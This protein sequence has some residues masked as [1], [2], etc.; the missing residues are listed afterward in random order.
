MPINLEQYKIAFTHIK[1]KL[2]NLPNYDKEEFFN[3]FGEKFKNNLS[4]SGKNIYAAGLNKDALAATYKKM[5]EELKSEYVKILD[6]AEKDALATFDPHATV[7]KAKNLLLSKLDELK[8]I[9]CDTLKH[10][11]TANGQI[12]DEEDKKE[13]INVLNEYLDNCGKNPNI[14]LG[15]INGVWP[16]VAKLQL[17]INNEESEFKAKNPDATFALKETDLDKLSIGA[18]PAPVTGLKV[19]KDN[20]SE[21]IMHAS[22]SGRKLDMELILSDWDAIFRQLAEIASHYRNPAIVLL[23]VLIFYFA[24]AI[25]NNEKRVVA[26]I[27]KVIEEKGIIINLEDITL[28][29]KRLD[30]NGKPVVI[31]EKA[32]LNAEQIKELQ[33]SN[34]EVKKKLQEHHTLQNKNKNPLSTPPFVESGYNSETEE[35]EILRPRRGP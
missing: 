13:L 35:E 5:D 7:E 2:V 10:E 20:L 27:K 18:A 9:L 29:I 28:T 24:A 1:N 8:I 19:H 12:F 17:H 30:N 31:R 33:L 26:A 25:F 22:A 21:Q 14:F 15:K 32:A 23:I 11:L 4:E 34:D 16:E 3:L 6:L